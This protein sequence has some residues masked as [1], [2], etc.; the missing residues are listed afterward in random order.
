MNFLVS[1][2]IFNLIFLRLIHVVAY[3]AASFYSLCVLQLMMGIW[4][5]SSL[6]VGILITLLWYL[7][8]DLLLWTW[9]LISLGRS[10]L[11]GVSGPQ[12]R[13]ILP[14]QETVYF[15]SL[16]SLSFLLIWLVWVFLYRP[17][18]RR[19]F[20]EVFSLFSER[21]AP[22]VDIVLMCS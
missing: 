5:V 18:F 8:Y 6:G 9:F 15:H 3:L 21:I 2:P 19:V 1:C 16:D 7:L 12:S 10:Y 13:C 14:F 4:V 11:V 22:C 17:G 20:L